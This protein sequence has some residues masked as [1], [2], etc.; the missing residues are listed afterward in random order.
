MKLND[1]KGL[2]RIVSYI[3]QSQIDDSDT[4]DDLRFARWMA[5]CI[6]LVVVNFFFSRWVYGVITYPATLKTIL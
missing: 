2:Y 1:G 5:L 3:S 4:V 6:F